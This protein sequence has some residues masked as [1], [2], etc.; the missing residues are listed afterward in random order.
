MQPLQLRKLQAGDEDQ[1]LAIL[2]AGKA[3]LKQDGVPQWQDGYP[4]AGSVAADKARDVGRVFV[5]GAQIVGYGALLLGVES[6]YREIAGAWR[7]AEGTLY[8]TIHRSAVAAHSERGT[9]DA[10]FAALEG[11]AR[12]RGAVS[13]RIDT[14]EKNVRMQKLLARSGYVH[15]GTIILA[16]TGE[17]RLAF[18][19]IL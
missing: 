5:C 12:G 11:E 16:D 4:D 2:N 9:A 13:V 3:K 8:A 10:F 14:H 15:C 19:K 7:T 1:V 17:S 18:E 6:S